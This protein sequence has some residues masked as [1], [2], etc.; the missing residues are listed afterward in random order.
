MTD[1]E[2]FP[3]LPEDQVECTDTVELTCP[4]CGKASTDS[5]ELVSEGEMS[6]GWCERNFMFTIVRTKTFS[7]TRA[8]WDSEL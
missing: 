7:S 8:D 4:Y 1:A 6:C 2:E 3:V 5:W